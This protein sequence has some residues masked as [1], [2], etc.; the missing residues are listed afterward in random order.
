MFRLIWFLTV[1]LGSPVYGFDYFNNTIDYWQAKEIT[2]E[3]RK[4]EPKTP[5]K[6]QPTL[7][8]AGFDWS[9]HMDPKNDE[10]FKEGDH[11]PPAPF[12]ELARNPTDENIK[13]WLSMIEMK[14]QMMERLHVSMAN[15]LQQNQSKLNTEEKN[16]ITQNVQKIAP[17]NIDVKRFRFRLYFESSC[18]HCHHMMAVV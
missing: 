13:R 16:L 15:Y 14:N 1:V 7:P 2:K 12:M 18:P 10:F 8:K 17:Q 6:E 5:V 4:P 11:T 3:Q 9:K